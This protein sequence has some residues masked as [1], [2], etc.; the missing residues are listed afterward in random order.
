[1]NKNLFN[2]ECLYQR[3]LGTVSAI[4]WLLSQNQGHSITLESE[5]RFFPLEK[6]VCKKRHAQKSGN[7]TETQT[8]ILET[9]IRLQHIFIRA[10]MSSDALKT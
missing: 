3:I 4:F 7:G 10:L 5:D 9:V 2:F 6:H 8:E 1:M